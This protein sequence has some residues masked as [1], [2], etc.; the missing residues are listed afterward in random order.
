MSLGSLPF[1]FPWL[2]AEVR[3][4]LSATS[5]ALAQFR[6]KDQQRIER[7][8]WYNVIALRMYLQR[9]RR[10]AAWVALLV[11]ALLLGLAA[12]RRSL[13]LAKTLERDGEWQVMLAMAARRQQ[14]LHGRARA[15]GVGT[16]TLRPMGQHPASIA[17]FT[18]SCWR[19]RFVT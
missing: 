17:L 11:G 4:T 2:H 19:D 9:L 1:A 5:R 13:A 16:P 8:A 15:G 14:L 7:V 10:P 18:R 3:A 12:H 6:S